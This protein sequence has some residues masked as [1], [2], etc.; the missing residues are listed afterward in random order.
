MVQPQTL[1]NPYERGTRVW[2]TESEVQG[3]RR[4]VLF[5]TRLHAHNCALHNILLASK[6]RTLDQILAEC[7][8]SPMDVDDLPRRDD[9]EVF[10]P[11]R[12]IGLVSDERTLLEGKMAR[13]NLLDYLVRMQNSDYIGRHPRRS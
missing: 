13:D 11:P 6:D 10:L 2:D 1:V 12:P 3:D 9:E 5:E 7:H 4:E 8:L